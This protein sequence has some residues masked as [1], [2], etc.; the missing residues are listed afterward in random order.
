MRVDRRSKPG[1]KPV[2]PWH[3]RVDGVGGWS[4]SLRGWKGRQHFLGH[5]LDHLLDPELRGHASNTCANFSILE[6]FGLLKFKILIFLY[7]DKFRPA[8]SV[9]QQ[10]QVLPK[11][12]NRR[13][14]T[15][16]LACNPTVIHGGHLHGVTVKHCKG[17]FTA[18]VKEQK[19]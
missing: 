6:H 11:I 8:A 16:P 3:P 5:L 7:S 10:I 9:M 19:S 15:V 1:A 2:D 4:C 18:S 13:Y 14:A 12:C 17:I